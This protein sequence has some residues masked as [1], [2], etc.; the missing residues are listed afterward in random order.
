MALGVTQMQNATWLSDRGLGVCLAIKGTHRSQTFKIAF[1][2]IEN[3][4]EMSMSNTFTKEELKT[5]LG[6]H[7]WLL[8]SAFLQT[9]RT[10]ADEHYRSEIPLKHASHLFQRGFC[11]LPGAGRKKDSS[12]NLSLSSQLQDP[13]K[14]GLP[15]CSPNGQ[16]PGIPST[17]LL[18]HTIFTCQN[19]LFFRIS[20]C[21]GL[22]MCCNMKYAVNTHWI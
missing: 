17:S 6:E 21:T 19:C 13:I 5:K 22:E 12:R 18:Q 15:L 4:C 16:W 20:S 1:Q 11:T 9:S 8:R 10:D 2:S 3:E 7:A 14:A